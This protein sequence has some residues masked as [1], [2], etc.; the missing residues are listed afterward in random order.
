MSC[1]STAASPYRIRLRSI[2][3]NKPHTLA[4]TPILAYKEW[5]EYQFVGSI[6]GNQLGLLFRSGQPGIRGYDG[7]AIRDWCAGDLLEVRPHL[8][9]YTMPGF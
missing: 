1:R 6:F 3:T 2:S 4:S 5:W 8:A 9:I 7:L